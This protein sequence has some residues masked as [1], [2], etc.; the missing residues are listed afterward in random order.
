MKSERA[1]FDFHFQVIGSNRSIQLVNLLNIF[2][3]EENVSGADADFSYSHGNIDAQ[4]GRFLASPKRLWTVKTC[5]L[6][7]LHSAKANSTLH[8]GL[9]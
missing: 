8:S 6:E 1:R 9:G 2:G 3:D 5:R 7:H 4:L